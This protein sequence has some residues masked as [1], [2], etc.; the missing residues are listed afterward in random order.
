MRNEGNPL[1]SVCIINYNQGRFFADALNSYLSQTYKELE[2]IVI[3][4]CS[5]DNSVEVINRL[6]NEKNIITNFICNKANQ[7]IC[8]NMNLGIAVGKGSYFSVVASDDYFGPKRYEKLMNAAKQADDSYKLFYSNCK[9][10]DE[11]GKILC[12]DFFSYCRPN[13]KNINGDIF[14]ELLNGNFIPAIALLIDKKVFCEV[15]KFDE[16]LRLEDFDMWLRIAR[17]FKVGFVKDDEVYY[18]Q[19]GNSWLKTLQKTGPYY[20]EHFNVVYRHYYYLNMPKRKKIVLI[21]YNYY[22]STLK[23]TKE[24]DLMMTKRMIAAWF[25]SFINVR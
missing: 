9:M 7:G 11:E 23:R 15:G 13:L 21:L 6:L 12:N 17:R 24:V 25:A 14:Y 2:L 10:V 4:D 22:K 3:D 18:R 19:V 8:K 1:I 20:K 5:T 16:S